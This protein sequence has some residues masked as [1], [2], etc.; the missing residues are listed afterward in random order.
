MGI[1]ICQDDACKGAAQYENTGNVGLMWRLQGNVVSA[2]CLDTLEADQ[3]PPLEL[4]DH[5]RCKRLEHV[6]SLMSMVQS[7]TDPHYQTT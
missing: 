5:R 3:L 2:A 1:K 6:H 4:H 7:I